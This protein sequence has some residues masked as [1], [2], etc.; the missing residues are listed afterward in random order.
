VARIERGYV[1]VSGAPGAG[2]STLAV[3]L[4]ARL[5]LPLIAKDV[6][7]E[8][9]YDHIPPRHDRAAWSKVLGGASM[10]LIWRLA[11]L[12]SAAV[13]EANFRPY[14][15]Y[16]RAKLASLPGPL[17]EVYCRCP[18]ALAAERFAAR[19][20]TR[21][22][23]HVSRTISAEFL[24]EFNRSIALGPVIEADT[25]AP[26]DIAVLASAVEAAFAACAAP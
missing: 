2:K 26:I 14:S 16:E 11:P 8:T 19:H 20:T 6:I 3:P 12:A 10:E 23:T 13:L 7:K 15:D 1:V 21:H 22:P 4:A 9:L 5:G 17:V 18:A 25:T 24:A